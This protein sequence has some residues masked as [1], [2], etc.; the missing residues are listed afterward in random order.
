MCVSGK[1]FIF[2]SHRRYDDDFAVGDCN[3]NGVVDD[4]DDDAIALA[5]V[6]VS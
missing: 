1:L 3:G 5:L 4:D 6:I 2:Y